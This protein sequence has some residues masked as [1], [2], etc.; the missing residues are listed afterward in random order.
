MVSEPLV[1]GV[2][3]SGSYCSAVLLQGGEVL[4]DV[5]QDMPKGQAE[6]L[7]PLL[8]DLLVRGG[9][10][11]RD[12]SAIGV[13]TGPGNFTGI[14]ISVSA[15]RGLALALEVP[16]IGVTLLD[17]LAHGTSGPV[18]GSIA[19]PRGQAYVQGHG[20]VQNVPPAL[21]AI[22][23]LQLDLAE[24]GLVSIGSAG[25]EIAARLGVPHVPA[26]YAP[27]SAIARIA[28]LRRAHDISP[29]APFYLKPADAAPARDAPPVLLD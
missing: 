15:M 3:T 9:A 8:Q 13:G 12:L 6:A 17:A 22:S 11:W 29:A 1:L 16:V 19:A 4:S 2:D 28:A 25:S 7:F 26:P 18:L 5:Y 20:M 24:P 27:G 14:R 21:V 10:T 23:D